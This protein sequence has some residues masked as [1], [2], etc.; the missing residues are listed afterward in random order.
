MR[1]NLILGLGLCCL[2][3]VFGIFAL[4][5]DTADVSGAWKV[6]IHAVDSPINEQWAL[7]QSGADVT[8]KI[9]GGKSDQDFTGKVEGTV[10]HGIIK[11]GDEK[12]IVEVSRYKDEMD[13]TIRMG[14]N[15]FLVEAAKAK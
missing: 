10:L 2:T 7:Q 12:Y 13:G 14:R 11:D 4:A 9:T 3:M 5:Q 8:G 6:T 15:E 1:R